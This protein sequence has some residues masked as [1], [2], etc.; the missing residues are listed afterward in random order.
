MAKKVT[1]TAKAPDVP[2]LHAA[3]VLVLA[4][5]P[6]PNGD[7]ALAMTAQLTAS[8]LAIKMGGGSLNAI[9][10]MYEASKSVGTSIMIERGD[11]G[12]YYLTPAGRKYATRLLK[13]APS[14]ATKP[15]K[16]PAGKPNPSTAIVAKLGLLEACAGIL[17]ECGTPKTARELSKAIIASGVWTPGGKTPYATVTAAIILDITKKG[18]DSEFRR[19]PDG[20]FVHA[21]HAEQFIDAEA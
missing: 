5:A 9:S 18:D 12:H 15:G 11:E 17:T 3:V 8:E 1:V 7:K 21:R 2:C 4:K 10:R 6:P 20:T 13:K 19:C 14:V 16:A